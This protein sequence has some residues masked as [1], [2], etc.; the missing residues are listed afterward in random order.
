MFIKPSQRRGK[1]S[2][3]S[4]SPGTSPLTLHRHLAGGRARR[5]RLFLC[6]C[7]ALAASLGA[8]LF[9]L[10]LALHL[11]L[12]G[13]GFLAG[14]AWRLAR[15]EPWALGWI[16]ERAGLA[17]R[18][19]LER[20]REEPIDAQDRYGFLAALDTQVARTAGRLEPPTAQP[21]W[22]PLLA[23]ALSLAVLPAVS[24]PGIGGGLGDGAPPGPNGSAP[25]AAQ[26]ETDGEAEGEADDET[27]GAEQEASEVPGAEVAQDAQPELERTFDAPGEDVSGEG[28]E[29]G[30]DGGA[31]SETLERY[32]ESL[33]AQED[34]PGEGSAERNPFARDEAQGEG[35]GAPQSSDAPD[36]GR[37]GERQ[38]EGE[39][40]EGQQGEGQQGQEGQGDENAQGAGEEGASGEG[41]P[42]QSEAPREGEQEAGS[43]EG[44]PSEQEQ[45]AEGERPQS[46]QGESE[47]QQEGQPQEEGQGESGQGEGD[48][49][50]GE[51]AQGGSAGP[52]EGEEEGGGSE[53][54]EGDGAGNLPSEATPSSAERLEGAPQTN[55]D[56]LEGQRSDGV[57]NQAGETLAPGSDAVDIPNARTNAEY[58]RA[59]E[60]AINEGR[61][62][63]EYQDILRDYF[64]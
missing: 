21:W 35:S 3:A 34:A 52:Q 53:G 51:S 56:L 23:V 48:P 61:I 5:T 22:L 11:A 50:Q 36:E 49:N 33:D 55:P 57:T 29:T 32:L 18:T 46:A 10:P 62:P 31:D 40:Q 7:F 43:S 2:A 39:R 25:P 26:S 16:D 28:G 8:W 30:A 13:A 15:A 60:E 45:E 1:T 58:E 41:A 59:A 9:D 38:G 64:R 24:L 12:V 4:T 17:Y 19:A 6:S 42:E 54:E 37:A 14:F 20:A 44:T 27:D 47:G 63:V